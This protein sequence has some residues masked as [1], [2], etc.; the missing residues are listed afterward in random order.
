LNKLWI[1]PVALLTIAPFAA[2]TPA[3]QTGSGNGALYLSCVT[4][5]ASAGTA[6]TLT[7]TDGDWDAFFNDAAAT[8]FQSVGD[9]SGTVPADATSVDACL[10]GAN[11]PTGFGA[12]IPSLGSTVTYTDG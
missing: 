12:P 6:F 10:W 5:T 7:S 2:A 11:D 3:S 9:E 8:L 1:L 4:F